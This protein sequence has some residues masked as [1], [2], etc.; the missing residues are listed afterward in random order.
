MRIL[1][2]LA[3]FETSEVPKKLVEGEIDYFIDLSK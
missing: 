1:L 3:Q 2:N